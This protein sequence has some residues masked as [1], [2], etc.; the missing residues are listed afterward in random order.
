MKRNQI[1]D[2][3]KGIGIFLVVLGHLPISSFL[4]KYIY[5]VHMPLFFFVSG[6][7]FNPN[8]N[9]KN[10]FVKKFSSIIKPYLLYCFLTY[11]LHLIFFK[12]INNPDTTSF[13]NF[14]KSVFYGVPVNGYLKWNPPLWFLPCLFSAI[15]IFYLLS[16]LKRQISMVLILLVLFMVGV[17]LSLNKIYLPFGVSSSLMALPFLFFGSYFRQKDGFV[18]FRKINKYWILLIS[19]FYTLFTFL[20][21]G[22]LNFRLKNYGNIFISYIGGIFGIMILIKISEKIKSTHISNIGKNSLFIFG[23]HV[24]TNAV[25]K[26]VFNFSCI[27]KDMVAILM[28]MFSVIIMIL[29][30]K[31]ISKNQFIKKNLYIY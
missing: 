23:F 7:L 9:F 14:L 6:F 29:V 10:F 2:N 17:L 15:L 19:A 26:R 27:S 20:N 30:I 4:F 16:K 22:F 25:A 24:F 21:K 3:L 12:L 8:L 13:L 18:F 5:G 1:I 28:A 31:I 11:F